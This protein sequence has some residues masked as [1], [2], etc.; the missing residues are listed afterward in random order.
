M[1]RTINY[2]D[3]QQNILNLASKYI[4]SK[5]SYKKHYGE[6]E[7]TIITPWFRMGNNK[8]VEIFLSFGATEAKPPE[9]VEAIFDITETSMTLIQNNLKIIDQVMESTAVFI[10]NKDSLKDPVKKEKI[11][12]MIVLLR[13]VVE[14]RK[15]L[16]IFVNVNKENLNDY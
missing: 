3:F 7:P 8:N 14:A 15:K 13:G 9:D 11:S 1:L 5:Q 2:Y 6:L 4:K 12:D 10:A 16:H